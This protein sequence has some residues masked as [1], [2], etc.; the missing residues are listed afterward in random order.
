MKILLTLSL[1]L[2]AALVPAVSGIH[3][4][5]G[6]TA[7]LNTVVISASKTPLARAQLTQSV[8]VITGDAIRARGITRLTD[9]L[10]EVPGVSVA[11]NGSFGSV[12]SLFLRGGESRYTKVLIDGVAV[13]QSGGFFDFSHLT[14]DNI[15]RIEIVRG[16][17]S[18]LYGA[19]AV[20][21]V[22]QI[23]T[24]R[25]KGPLTIRADARG[26]TY[27]TRDAEL[28]LSG[29]SPGFS[30]SLAGANHHTD[31]LFDFNNDYDNGTL[32]GAIGTTFKTGADA[33]ISARYG[34]AEFHYPTDY[35]GAP[36]DTNSYRVQHRL[37]VGGKIGTAF[38]DVAR[39]DVLAGT[40]EVWDLTEDIAI[41]FFG[42]TKVHSADDSRAHR[43]SLEARLGLTSSEAAHLNVGGELVWEGERNTSGSGPVGSPTTPT[44]EFDADRTTRGLYAELIGSPQRFLTYTAAARVDD[45]SDYG[46]HTTYR[47]GVSVPIGLDIRFRGSLSTAFNAPAFNQIRATLFST[48]SPGLSP[49]KTRSWEIGMDQDLDNESGRVSIVYFRQRF[50]DLIQYVPGGPPTYLGAYANLTEARSNGYEAEL[51]LIPRP[52]WSATA[53]YTRVTPRVTRVSPA[54]SGDL[55]PGDA[56]IRRPTHSGSTTVTFKPRHASLSAL[57]TYVGKR[58]DLDFNEFPSPTVTLPAYLKLDLAG[59]Y[60]IWRGAHHS[61]L[62]IT[63]R[64]ENVLDKEYETVLH[65]PAPGRVILLGARFSGSL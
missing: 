20:T 24:R 4:Q 48:A 17:A 62:S 63:G 65:F 28:A 53:S 50:E 23:F 40:N 2:A 14:T 10:Q 43:R 33:A 52:L 18:V 54:Y 42:T 58:A 51:V 29:G 35:T 38:S 25:G 61:L 22:I 41:P 49:E 36:V 46:S 16:P 9:A 32:S 39:L 64:V 56:L 7:T 55:Q 19:D 47:L 6:D 1:S 45:N 44:S 21:G 59:S 30:Y 31:G 37:T 34:A 11:Q 8:T 12:T 15:D 27:D 60:D 57:A 13:N 5:E 3:A 26:G